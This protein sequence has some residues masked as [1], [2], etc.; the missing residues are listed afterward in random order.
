MEELEELRLKLK[1]HYIIGIIITIIIT[2]IVASFKLSFIIFPIVLGIVI[3]LLFTS[4]LKMKYKITFK[5]VFVVKA[6]ESKFTDLVYN[7]DRGIPYETISG[8]NMMRMGDRYRSEDFISAKYKGMTKKEF[9]N[10]EDKK[11]EDV[12][13]D[14]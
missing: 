1:G 10:A 8:T 9:F 11:R 3:T 13:I 6:L 12:K 14:L 2:A 5:K 7:P 4:K